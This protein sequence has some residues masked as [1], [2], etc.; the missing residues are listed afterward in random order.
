VKILRSTAMPVALEADD[1]AWRR[2]AEF[3]RA[4]R[5]T[6][7]PKISQQVL[8]ERAGISVTTLRK[9]ENVHGPVSSDTLLSIDEAFGWD[10]GTCIDVLSATTL[11]DQLR[12]LVERQ[13]MLAGEF[14]RLWLRLRHWPRGPH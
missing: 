10:E 6:A 7:S 14:E 13:K 5:A 1:A 2:L 11:S 8:A 9:V 12:T 3:V 4:A